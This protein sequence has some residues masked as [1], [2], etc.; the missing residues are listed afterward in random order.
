VCSYYTPFYNLLTDT[1]AETPRMPVIV[2][3]HS[4]VPV[5]MDRIRDVEVGIL[6]DADRRL[7][8]RKLEPA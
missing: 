7:A 2:T 5:Y 8:D 1:I 4:F 6:H 3:I